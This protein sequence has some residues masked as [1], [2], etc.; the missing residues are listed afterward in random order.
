MILSSDDNLT[1]LSVVFLTAFFKLSVFALL[2]VEMASLPYLTH[3]L[4]P[5]NFPSIIL[6]MVFLKCTEK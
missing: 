2:N 3:Q 1:K 5:R 6:N 4:R